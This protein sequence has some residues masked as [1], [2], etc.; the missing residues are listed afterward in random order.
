[1][2]IRYTEAHLSN[3]QDS[4]KLLLHKKTLTENPNNNHITNNICYS[5]EVSIKIFPLKDYFGFF[6]QGTE[7]SKNNVMYEYRMET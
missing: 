4:F 1:M 5:W 2:L 3:F 7:M 6:E